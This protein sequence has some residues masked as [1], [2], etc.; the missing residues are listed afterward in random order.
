MDAVLQQKCQRSA[1]S[2]IAKKRKKEKKKLFCFF[3]EF[4]HLQQELEKAQQNDK[5][6]TEQTDNEQTNCCLTNCQTSV[7][8][9]KVIGV[10]IKRRESEELLRMIF[11]FS[12]FKHQKKKKVCKKSWGGGITR[13]APCL[14]RLHSTVFEV[15]TDHGYIKNPSPT[16]G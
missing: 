14:K 5:N 12:T 10:Q 13:T 8:T 11:C 9:G 4:E 15:D 7:S 16:P 2:C 1:R 3:S 6:R